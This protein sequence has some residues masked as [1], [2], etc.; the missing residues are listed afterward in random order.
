MAIIKYYTSFLEMR[1]VT[2]EEVEDPR[3]MGKKLQKDEARRRIKELG[4]IMVY[5]DEDGAIWD[6]PD[7]EFYEEFKGIGKEIKEM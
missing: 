2:Y 1:N 6:T 4:L 5:N 7:R 3:K